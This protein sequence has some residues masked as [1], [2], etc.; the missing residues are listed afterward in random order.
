MN[1]I[2]CDVGWKRETTRNAIALV[3][4]SGR[5]NLVKGGLD[6]K[7]LIDLVREWA[8]PQSLILLDVPIDGCEKLERGRRSIENALQHY[9]SLYPASRAGRR[10]KQLK[11][12]LLQAMPDELRG[13]IIIK[14][15]YPY[16]IYKFLWVAKQKGKLARI[17]Q[18]R[19]HQNILDKNFTT[20]ISV[21]KYKG[22]KVKYEDRLRGM[23]KLYKFLT[24]LLDLRFSQSLDFPRISSSRSGLELLA[25]QYDACLG[26]VA[27]MYW[28]T[29]NSYAWL[30][31][32]ESQG[33]I[34]ILADIWLK[35]RLEAYGI[36]MNC[37]H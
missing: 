1:I 26:A 35:E 22:S 16:A 2:S 30:A 14:E 17:R 27:G 7:H 13:S 25:D 10:G 37:L 19:E 32:D 24:Q 21:P 33:E 6:D 4:D 29:G 23:R 9:I 36:N 15:I 34:L 11:E 5:V 12:K 31:G 18:Q 20:S 28:V 3:T 8:E